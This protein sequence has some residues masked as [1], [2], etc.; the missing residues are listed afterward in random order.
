MVE[1]QKM[2]SYRKWNVRN[3]NFLLHTIRVKSCEVT[4]YSLTT[5]TTAAHLQEQCTIRQT[6]PHWQSFFRAE[7]VWSTLV[8]KNH[9]DRKNL[10]TLG[11]NNCKG[12]ERPRLSPLSWLGKSVPQQGRMVALL[13][14]NGPSPRGHADGLRPHW[15]LV[16]S[17]SLRNQFKSINIA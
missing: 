6:S 17:H 13:L 12:I 15:R 2:Q 10:A 16:V 9:R 1:Q 14:S 5:I 11:S 7:T 4:R 8:K 3:M